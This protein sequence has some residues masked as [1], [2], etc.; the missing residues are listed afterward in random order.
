MTVPAEAPSTGGRR[1]GG[2][3]AGAGIVAAVVYI[4]NISD[5]LSVVAF[6][7]VG[8]GTVWAC[9]VGP[10][11]FGAEPRTAWLSVSAA[12]LLFLIGVV[13]RPWATAQ[14]PPLDLLADAAT[15]PGYLLLAAFFLILVRARQSIE[16]HAVLDGLIVCLAGGL[17]TALLLAAPALAI[18]GRPAAV[19]VVAGTYPLLDIVLLLLV[20]NLTFTTSVFPPSLIALLGGMA[21]M[22]VGDLAYAII[23]VAGETY[24]SP[25]LDAPFLLSYTLLG[26]AALHPSVVDLSRATRR[27]VQAW[28]WQRMSLL[29]PATA[30][31]F[32][33]LMLVGARSGADRLIIAGTGAV[34]VILLLARAV[35]AV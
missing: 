20:V 28:S 23:G 7:V 16:R 14:P 8:L 13:I 27:P 29:V 30:S 22:F 5:I 17:V 25:L 11:R 2:A 31:P 3:F 32:V 12:A 24:S 35:S 34:M 9:F 33:L 10:R 1:Q 18:Q 21:L 4:A 6:A 15:V 26:V 19:S